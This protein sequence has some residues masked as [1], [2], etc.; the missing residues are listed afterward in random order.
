MYLCLIH[1]IMYSLSKSCRWD[2]LRMH[3]SECGYAKAIASYILR[4]QEWKRGNLIAITTKFREGY[5]HHRLGWSTAWVCCTKNP[6]WCNLKRSC[7]MLL[8]RTYLN[9]VRSLTLWFW[10][11]ASLET[12]HEN[13]KQYYCLWQL[14]HILI[15]ISLNRIYNNNLFFYNLIHHLL[16]I[17]ITFICVSQTREVFC[18]V[19]FAWC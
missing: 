5:R 16:F 14:I 3:M 2:H 9:T 8:T 7:S 10:I 13:W 1:L 4:R 6:T 17:M 11:I 15:C 12:A 18:F 19:F